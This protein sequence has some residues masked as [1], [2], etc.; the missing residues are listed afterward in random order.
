MLASMPNAVGLDVLML[1]DLYDWLLLCV[2]E[3]LGDRKKEISS[4]AGGENP[5]FLL[6]L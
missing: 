4:I 2:W 1:L 5:L 6:V 3:L